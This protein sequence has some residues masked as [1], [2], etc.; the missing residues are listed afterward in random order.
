M[1]DPPHGTLGHNQERGRITERNG[2]G[3][4]YKHDA[5][6]SESARNTHTR[7]RFVLVS[8]LAT[9]ILACASCLYATRIGAV[10][11]SNDARMTCRLATTLASFPWVRARVQPNNRNNRYMAPG[12]T[13]EHAL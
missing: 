9:Y 7:L 6:A 1:A 12:R 11:A 10:A 5:L 8:L 13:D 3:Q 4:K 2:A